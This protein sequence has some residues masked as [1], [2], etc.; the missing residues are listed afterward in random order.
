MEFHG[1]NRVTLFEALLNELRFVHKPELTFIQKEYSICLRNKVCN[2]QLVTALQ[3]KS[4]PGFRGNFRFAVCLLS[5]LN[6]DT[7]DQSSSFVDNRI[8][9]NCFLFLITNQSILSARKIFTA[10]SLGDRGRLFVQHKIY[11][12]RRFSIRPQTNGSMIVGEMDFNSPPSKSSPFAAS[13][14]IQQKPSGRLNGLIENKK[15]IEL[16]RCI[17]HRAFSVSILIVSPGIN[18]VSISKLKAK[19]KNNRIQLKPTMD[20]SIGIRWSIQW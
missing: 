19:T 17:R 1:F 3:W 15:V 14:D 10:K 13:F 20:L 11:K 16:E 7:H 6:E 4:Q 2:Q 5:K 8:C 12:Y 18:Q 9:G